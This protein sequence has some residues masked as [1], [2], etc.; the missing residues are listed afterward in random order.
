MESSKTA[1]RPTRKPPFA[2]PHV[3]VLAVMDGQD[4][5]AVHRLTQPET[6]IGRTPEADFRV[7]DEAVSNRHCLIRVDGPVCTLVEL[8]SRNGTWVNARPVKRE[9]IERLRHLDVI[10]LGDTRIMFLYAR[11]PEQLDRD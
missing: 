1:E 5:T 7:E 4:A 10:Q 6:V 2:A 8:G 11:F 9:R 3:Y